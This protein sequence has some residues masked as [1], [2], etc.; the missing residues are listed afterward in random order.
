MEAELGQY[1]DRVKRTLDILD[2]QDFS[3]RLWDK[4]ASLWRQDESGAKVIRKRLGWLNIVSRISGQAD[5]IAEF[6][7]G[8]K[9]AGFKHAVLMGMGGS[10]LCPEVSRLTF[11]VKPG[12]PDLMVLDS[13]VPETILKLENQINL[14]QT[15]FIVSTKAGTTVETMSAYHYFREKAEGKQFVA[16]TDPDTP[17]EE[18]VHK[19]GFRGMFLNPPDIGGRYSALSYFG[20][21]PAAIIGMD[22]KLL[23]DRAASMVKL[24]G[25]KIRPSENTGIILGAI[26][27][28]LA[29][30]GRDKLTLSFSPEIKSFGG[31]VEQLVAEST[32]NHGAGIL[33]VEGDYSGDD[34]LTVYMRLKDEAQ[35][36]ENK[37]HVEFVLDD[38]YDLGKEYFRWEIAAAVAGALLGVNAFDQPNIQESKD[39]TDDLL[40]KPSIPHS[41]LP[42]PHLPEFLGQYRPGD[43][44]ALM[45]FLDK[46]EETDGLLQQI[47]ARIQKTCQ[48]PVTLGYGPSFLHSTGQFHKGGPNNGLFIQFTADDPVDVPIPGEEFTFSTLKQ[49][50]AMGDAKAL[51]SRGRP[52]MHIH[53]GSDPVGGLKALLDLIEETDSS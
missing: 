11:G 43:Y 19:V 35:V 13:T 18:E 32:G 46:S 34:S 16:I 41:A 25:P 39:I 17:L 14:G 29:L 31:W 42:T 22:I 6:A 40:K 51:Q 21:V 2:K 15:L 53:L 48:A 20:L 7:E 8:I 27:A 5:N 45:A 23:L 10:S 38:V 49:A 3:R 50:Q 28:E 30:M 4:D 52:F 37:P 9:R 26:I 12:Y 24:C 44:F 1:A 33:P 47:R 36:P